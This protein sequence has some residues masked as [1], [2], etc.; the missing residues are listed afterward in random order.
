MSKEF[1]T[2]KTANLVQEA[3]S[4]IEHEGHDCFIKVDEYN[5]DGSAVCRVGKTDNPEETWKM[6]VDHM[7]DYYGDK[8]MMRIN[9]EGRRP[10]YAEADPEVL[11]DLVS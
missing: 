11:V 10:F 6:T 2:K 4:I 9:H 1:W 5:E 8:P 7:R 3:I